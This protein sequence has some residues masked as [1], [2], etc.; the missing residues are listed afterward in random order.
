MAV[1]TSNALARYVL[2]TVE[3]PTSCPPWARKALTGATEG[4]LYPDAD[5]RP[6]HVC[7]PWATADA[8]AVLG[9]LDVDA[10]LSPASE[11]WLG[12]V[13]GGALSD[14]RDAPK[15]LARL[16]GDVATALRAAFDTDA[17]ALLGNARDGVASGDAGC[18]AAGMRA[19]GLCEGDQSID[20]S[21][22]HCR[23]LGSV[24]CPA[25]SGYDDCHSGSCFDQGLKPPPCRF[26]RRSN[27]TPCKA[28]DTKQRV[29][30]PLCDEGAQK[31]PCP[32]CTDG[33]VP[34]LLASSDAVDAVDDVD[35]APGESSGALEAD[36][37][38]DS[39]R[40]CAGEPPDV[41]CDPC[42]GAGYVGCASCH[43]S[44]RTICATCKGRALDGG[45]CS[46]CK[47]RGGSR[48]TT[49][50][51][52]R[53]PCRSCAS[54][55][56]APGPAASCPLCRGTNIHPRVSEAVAALKS[57]V[58]R[59]GSYARE[60]TLRKATAFLMQ[61]RDASGHFTY[62][63]NVKQRRPGDPT[64]GA[65]SLT[66]DSHARSVLALVSSGV[67]HDDE[68]LARAWE[69]LRSDAEHWPE[70]AKYD[71]VAVYPA[72]CLSAIVLGGEDPSAHTVTG[73]VELLTE[74]QQRDG[75]WARPSAGGY[76]ES[77]EHR[78][79]LALESL[80]LAQLAGAA[81]EK[82]VWKRALKGAE[83]RLGPDGLR[84]AD[85][86]ITSG[87]RIAASLAFLIVAKAG[88]LTDKQ[89]EEF[90]FRDLDGVRGGLAWL[91]RH[92]SWSEEPLTGR[93]AR[94]RDRDDRNR[95]AKFV[96]Y[97][98][99]KLILGDT[100][101]LEYLSLVAHLLQLLDIEFFAGER[102]HPALSR[103]LSDV[104]LSAGEY[105]DP[106]NLGYLEGPGPATA[107]A[108]LLLSR[109]TPSARARS[110]DRE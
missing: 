30:C 70:R 45:K 38:G 40:W 94:R 43:G 24:T 101:H 95:G 64:Y 75:L 23:G 69:E 105:I 52:G 58:G 7:T 37:T 102:W 84:G 93:G 90:D 97:R 8:A 10:P 26:C 80:R 11:T 31:R 51:S 53:K 78:A 44:E 60:Q 82:S 68:T 50:D 49:C 19:C 16:D 20:V 62:P 72:L 29:A 106:C 55:G 22:L 59:S 54:S 41:V 85:T 12:L 21:C 87:S 86:E 48:C 9:A 13:L 46:A 27:K 36:S 108:I 3:V 99:R 65:G 83:S 81:V 35:D 57:R 67:R 109:A 89:I 107:R 61:C 79:F 91:E 42:G 63:D 76:Q 17:G 73:L 77:L 47:G 6:D 56:L 100:R 28:C 66:Y 32:L 74:K 33:R 71:R 104:Q 88:T 15:R 2:T 18:D 14:V 98:D 1:E 25:C 103:Y 39:C 92:H 110:L 5:R 4:L 96:G 34:C